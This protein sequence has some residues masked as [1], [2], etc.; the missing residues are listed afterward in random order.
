MSEKKQEPTSPQPIITFG[1]KRQPFRDI[2]HRFLRASWPVAL[3]FIV[4][5]F[6]FLNA[7]YAGLYMEIGGIANAR[8]GSFADAFFFAGDGVGF[9][10][11]AELKIEPGVFEQL[12]LRAGLLEANH[13]IASAVSDQDALLLRHG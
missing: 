9:F 5:A 12:D 4:V 11:L 1:A 7:C 6:L 8:P 2:Y 13:G 10:E 3:G